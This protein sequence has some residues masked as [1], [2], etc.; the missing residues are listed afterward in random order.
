MKA[1]YNRKG[2]VIRRVI[3]TDHTANAMT[4]ITQVPTADGGWWNI[5]IERV[6]R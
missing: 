3:F 2:E 6:G 5:T 4:R 1:T